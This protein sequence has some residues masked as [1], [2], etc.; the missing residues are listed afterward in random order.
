MASG[1]N[2]IRSFFAKLFAELRDPSTTAAP[3]VDVTD[4]PARRTYDV[5]SVSSSGMLSGTD[6]FLFAADNSILRQQVVT[7]HGSEPASCGKVI[8]MPQQ[9]SQ[10]LVPMDKSY[11]KASVQEAWDN[12]FAAFGGQDLQDFTESSELW[13]FDHRTF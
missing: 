12:H 3:V 4:A 13:A 8:Q 7:T 11:A 10:N 1:L 6:T 2:E 9:P 5:W